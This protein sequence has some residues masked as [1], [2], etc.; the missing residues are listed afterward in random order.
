M[1][2]WQ[3]IE[4][5][6]YFALGFLVMGLLGLLFLPFYWSRAMRLSRL[7]IEAQLP[8]SMGEIVAQR[9][10]LRAEF[11]ANTRRI[12]MKAEAA[13]DARAADRIERGRR[14][15][16]IAGLGNAIV[17]ANSALAELG[18]A[19]AA[20]LRAQTEA[21]GQLGAASIELHDAA[22][23]MARLNDS[24]FGLKRQHEDLIEQADGQRATIA[25]LETRAAGQDMRLED[26]QSLADATNSARQERAH[27]A[28]RLES[29]LREAAS[30]LVEARLQ[31]A[32]LQG[33]HDKA[34][35]RI[36]QLLQ[37]LDT[38]RDEHAATSGVAAE[39]AVRSRDSSAALASALEREQQLRASL[40]RQIDMARASDASLATRADTLR[41]EN[42]ALQGALDSARSEYASLR[43]TGPGEPV[44]A[45]AVQPAAASVSA[46]EIALLREAVTDIGAEM[47]RLTEAL[48]LD[49]DNLPL[50]EKLR[51][52][53]G[54][55]AR[56]ILSGGTG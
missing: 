38:E 36:D 39:H 33:S 10:A 29:E 21:E 51:Q 22:G 6:M 3:L 20:A 34:Q 53:Q 5:A 27:E 8:L 31:Q 19:H 7:Q 45:A 25:A 55:A 50:A 46:E 15:V 18:A 4:Q 48:E 1:R 56:G 9:D 40:Q 28:E 54:Y 52:L 12:E 35:Q 2:V 43:R 11:S 23:L 49:G 17:A 30:Q 16:T 44:S 26:L 37:A 24:H 42:A 41:M 14:D 32:R 47:T 13:R